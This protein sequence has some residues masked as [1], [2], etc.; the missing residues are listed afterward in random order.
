M[1]YWKTKYKGKDV[2]LGDT[3]MDIM[4]EAING[5]IGIY[6]MEFGRKPTLEEIKAILDRK[7]TRLNSSH[8]V[9]SYAVFCL[10]KKIKKDISK[11]DKS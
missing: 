8:V 10:K 9:I 4:I 5:I 1:D 2:T 3:S 11:Y 7:S 6:K